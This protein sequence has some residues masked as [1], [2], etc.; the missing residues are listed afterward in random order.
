[1][2][3]L[4][5]PPSEKPP[6][7]S[8]HE[9]PKFAW[10]R[11]SDIAREF[12]PLFERHWR[13]IAL[14][15]DKIKLDPLWDTYFKLD[16]AGVLRVLTV[17]SKGALIGYHFVLVLPHLHYAGTLVGETDMFWLDPAYRGGLTGYRL[18]RMVRDDLK[19]EGVKWHKMAIKRHKPLTALMKRLGYTPIETVYSK[20]F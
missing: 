5:D 20:V 15:Q 8:G 10:E 4:L 16:L 19:A 12:P 9:Q 3:T 11:F 17:R 7:L 18:L 14:N 6:V 2:L 13:E 1:M